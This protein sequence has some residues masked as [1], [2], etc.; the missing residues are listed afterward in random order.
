MPDYRKRFVVSI[1]VFLVLGFLVTTFASYFV[2]RDTLRIRIRNSE[3]PL[4]SDNIY[5]EIQRDLL[6]PVF[7]SSLMAHDTFLRDW[8]IA[9]ENDPESIVRYLNEIKIKYNTFTS[10]FVSEKTS[11]YYYYKGVLKD[12]NPDEPRDQWY[13]RVQKMPEDFEINVD[14]DLANNDAMTIFVNHKVFDFSGN[15]IGATGVG[16]TINSVKA[17]I[18]QYQQKYNRSVF[19]VDGSGKIVVTDTQLTNANA[20]IKDLPGISTIAP[21]MYTS[22]LEP[23]QTSYERNGKRFFV[24]FRFIPELKWF[25][26]VEQAEEG[27]LTEIFNAMLLNILL[28]LLVTALVMYLFNYTLRTYRQKLDQLAEEDMELRNINK[29]QSAEI[30]RQNRELLEKNA[31]LIDAMAQVKKLSGFLPI[32]S[33]CKKIRDDKG[34]WNQIE[35]Y[36]RE[37]SEARFSH[38]ICPD[39]MA[40]L[41]PEFSDKNDSPQSGKKD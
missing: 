3:L 36:L 41:Y 20:N 21:Q 27:A 13:F 29:E 35:A 24:N 37:H 23:V 1:A 32:C 28:C 11:R 15:Y 5:S 17:L 12:V 10:F 18:D 38:G 31:N 14:P 2:A 25:I 19:F 34:Y 40:T 22:C 33:G 30:S 6:R 26:V 16:L 8:A 4:T 9:G 39:C 7:I